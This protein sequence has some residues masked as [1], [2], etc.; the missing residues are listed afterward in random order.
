MDWKKIGQWVLGIVLSA[1]IG[2]FGG[3]KVFELQLGSQ[4][5]VIELKAKLAELQQKQDMLEKNQAVLADTML[6]PAPK[7]EK[8]KK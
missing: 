7:L 4:K 5:I 1:V 6:V 8:K 3:Q 2:W